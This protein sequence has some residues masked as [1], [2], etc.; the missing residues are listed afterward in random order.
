M[1]RVEVR[2]ERLF[3]Q[4]LGRVLRKDKANKKKFGLIIDIN[5]KSSIE[6]CNRV[7]R[8]MRITNGFLGAFILKR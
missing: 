5:A 1:D 7:Q 3:V 6:L 4:S 2:S 8:Y